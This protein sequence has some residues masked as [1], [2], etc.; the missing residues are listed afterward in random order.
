MERG[1]R[2]MRLSPR[3]KADLTLLF[4]TLL[5]GSA[6]AV[7]RQALDPGLVFYLNGLRLL[8]GGALL[9]PLSRWQ[10]EKV[11]KSLIAPV[12]LTG[13]ALFTG[14]ALQMI[15]LAT[16]S[17]GNAG[18][19]T[20][21]YVVFVPFL[22]WA[23]WGEKPSPLLLLAVALAILGGFLLSTAGTYRLAPGD[24][25]VAASAIFWALH[26]VLIGRFAGKVPSI[27]YAAGQFFVAGLLSLL[28]ALLRETP[29]AAGLMAL[30][31][32]ILYTG[33]FSIAAGFTLQVYGQRHTPSGDAALILSLEAVF[34]A[35]FGW[36]LLGEI[37]LPLQLLGCGL[38][39]AGVLL[40][41]AREFSSSRK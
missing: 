14:V 11:E 1:R 39:L 6:F 32:S 28:M 4:V 27:A 8:L 21:L 9:I 5:W 10:K 3:L 36:L 13:A 40:S 38:I 30:L 15:G 23:R 19:L 12:L 24:L 20:S 33:V 26:V 22:L 35:F 7:L 29:S 41:Q 34:A 16:T 18:F 37:L 2:L 31:P 17:A 25:W